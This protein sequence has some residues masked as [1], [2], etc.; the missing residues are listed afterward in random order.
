MSLPLQGYGPPIRR[1]PLAVKE[2]HDL[3]AKYS[4]L[5]L[6]ARSKLAKAME[7]LRASTDRIEY[8]DK[9]VDVGAALSILFMEDEEQYEPALL[10]SQRAAWYYSDSVDE[11]R[12]TE[13]MLREFLLAT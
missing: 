3:A 4:S 12:D 10:I 2:L 5:P 8:G 6:R 13:D 11:R 7:R 1:R 9:I